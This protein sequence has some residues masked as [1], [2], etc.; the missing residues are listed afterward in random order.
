MTRETRMGQP[1]YTEFRI[2]PPWPPPD[3]LCLDRL[4]EG[5][6]SGV[7]IA[8]ALTAHRHFE[9]VLAHQLLIVVRTVLG[10]FKRSSQLMI[11]IS[12]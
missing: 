11:S 10:G 3:Q 5:L 1:S 9:A 4:E 7:V 2:L 6:D 12:F 8:V